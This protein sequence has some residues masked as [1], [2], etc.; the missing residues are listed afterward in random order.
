MKMGWKKNNLFAS[1]VILLV[2]VIH[3]AI[4]VAQENSEAS[5]SDTVQSLKQRVIEL[6]RDLFI[7][8]EELLFPANT[9]VAVFLSMDVGEFFQLDAVNLKIDGKEVSNYLYTEKQVDALFRGGIQRLHIGNVR[10]GEHEIAAFF[11]GR[12]PQ[13]RDY[14]RAVSHTFKKGGDIKYIELQIRDSIQLHQPALT[15]KEWQ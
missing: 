2:S 6:N 15:V 7:L 12:G 5:V 8:E 10:S 13:G 14:R 1:F 3:S 4:S 11:T 9:Q